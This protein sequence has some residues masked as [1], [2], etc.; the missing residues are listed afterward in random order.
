M[1]KGKQFEESL[2]KSIPDYAL[3]YRLPDPAQSFGGG[4]KTR[5]SRH[6]PFDFLVFSPPTKTLYALEAKTVKGKSIS[7]ERNKNEHGEIHYYQIAGLNEWNK[8]DGIVC[9]FIIEFRELEITVFINIEEFNQLIENIN[10]KSFNYDDLTS[11]GLSY[12]IIPQK[13]KRTKYT[14]DIDRFLQTIY[15]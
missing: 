13:K 10:K 11:S 5:F 3:L 9:G 8:Y 6:N 4:T 2:K 1:N 14:Y 12:F 15:E 7:F